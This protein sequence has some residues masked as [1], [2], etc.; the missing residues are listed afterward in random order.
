MREH[1]ELAA[2]LEHL[3]GVER[4]VVDRDVAYR[5]VHG[6]ELDAKL[7]GLGRGDVAARLRDD[8]DVGHGCSPCRWRARPARLMCATTA[9]RHAA[10]TYAP[11]FHTRTRPS[12]DKEM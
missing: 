5:N 3:G 6:H 10:V 8:D 9:Q 4:P 7:G 2:L 1:A 12:V 11:L